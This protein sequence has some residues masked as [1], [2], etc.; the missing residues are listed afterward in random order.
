MSFKDSPFPKR[1]S[2]KDLFIWKDMQIDGR[3]DE[4]LKVFQP[5]SLLGLENTENSTER[6]IPN[7]YIF[8]LPFCISQIIVLKISIAILFPLW[9]LSMIIEPQSG[10]NA[11]A[12]RLIQFNTNVNKIGDGEEKVVIHIKTTPCHCLCYKS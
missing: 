7:H 8:Y 2:F 12:R 6:I 3:K 4:F 10:S 5:H 11:V 9:F 1:S